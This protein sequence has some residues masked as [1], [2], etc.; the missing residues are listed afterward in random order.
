MLY[1][2][3]KLINFQIKKKKIF[4][5]IIKLEK[6][7]LEKQIKNDYQYDIIVM[8][9]ILSKISGLFGNNIEQIIYETSNNEYKIK[10]K[11]HDFYI[12]FGFDK[13]D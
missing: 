8:N 4:N 2:R 11:N 3:R 9:D 6:I 7:K 13:D 10:L 5:K 12:I 1:L